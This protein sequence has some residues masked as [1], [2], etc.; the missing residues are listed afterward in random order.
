MENGAGRGKVRATAALSDVL[1]A[2]A[3]WETIKGSEALGAMDGVVSFFFG[4]ALLTE[5]SL[6]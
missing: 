3:N 1:T 6:N 2:N 4:T 5:W